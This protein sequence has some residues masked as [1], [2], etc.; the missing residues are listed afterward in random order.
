MQ[1]LAG[2][3]HLLG[4]G[5]AFP[6]R[7]FDTLT[8]ATSNIVEDLEIGLELA[9]AGHAPIA[10]E[11]TQVFSDAATKEATLEQRRRWEGGYLT[12]AARSVPRTFV[13]SAAAGSFRGI[14][15]SLDLLIPPLALLIILDG[16]AL[17]LAGLATWLTGAAVWP[18]LALAGTLCFAGFGLFLAWTAGGSRYVTLGALVQIPAYVIWKLP[19]YL[20]LAHHGAPKQWVRT[21]RDQSADSKAN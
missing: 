18:V 21:T 2:R 8:L 6:W 19:L 20:R 1:R 9:D 14:W 13:R 11:E 10:V 12:A 17:V 4:T 16:V 15:A 5:M 7:L 3:V